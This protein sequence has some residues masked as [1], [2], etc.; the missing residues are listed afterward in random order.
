MLS[1][2]FTC[3]IGGTLAEV[4]T[5]GYK[6]GLP[7]KPGRVDYAR[8]SVLTCIYSKICSPHKSHW[9]EDNT[10]TMTMIVSTHS[11][12][13]TSKIIYFSAFNNLTC[14]LI[15]TELQLNLF[16]LMTIREHTLML[17]WCCCHPPPQWTT[18]HWWWWRVS[19]TVT[20]LVRRLHTTATTT[21]GLPLPLWASSLQT[22]EF[23]SADLYYN[24]S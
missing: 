23:R 15:V 19:L 11:K 17:L 5:W 24:S 3:I 22:L 14:I 18:E 8:Y 4:R 9:D 16:N 12:L 21:R 13:N 10:V 7:V 20:T 2:H 1:L 6:L